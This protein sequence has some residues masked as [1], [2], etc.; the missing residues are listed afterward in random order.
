MLSSQQTKERHQPN[1]F[2]FYGENSQPATNHPDPKHHYRNSQPADKKT[3][4]VEV[5]DFGGED[6]NNMPLDG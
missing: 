5:I 3:K 6:T 1:S 2:N 4:I